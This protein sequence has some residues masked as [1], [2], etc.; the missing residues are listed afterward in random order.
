[1]ITSKIPVNLYKYLNQGTASKT[2]KSNSVIFDFT[3]HLLQLKL[4]IM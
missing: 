4:K 2:A 1:M 3:N